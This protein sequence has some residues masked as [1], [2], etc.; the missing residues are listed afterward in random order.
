MTLRPGRA[1]CNLLTR[2]GTHQEKYI[3]AASYRDLR[4]WQNA[5]ELVL[6]VYQETQD[7][8][9]EE[10][11][12]LRSQMGELRSQFLAILLRAK[13]VRRIVTAPCS[14]VTLEVHFWNWRLRFS[15]LS[16]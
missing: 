8:P 14:S 3:V 7:F 13:A 9:K 1:L 15:S 2:A 12:G 4:V 16:G 11:Y 6:C 5:M 10:L